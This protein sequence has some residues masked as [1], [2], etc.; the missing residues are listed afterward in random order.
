MIKKRLTFAGQAATHACDGRCD[1]AWGINS[2]PSIPSRADRQDAAD[3]DDYAFLA[4]SELGTAP[5]D[6][7]TYEGGHAKP[8][9]A[10]G[11]EDINKWCI[12]ECE[13]SWMSSPGKPDAPPD[14]PDYSV[15]HYNKAPH[16]RETPS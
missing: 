10:K 8:L 11:P 16:R 1:K 9:A 5:A 3:P 15:R 2:R 13:R 12:R 6:P 4:D 7:G 14:L